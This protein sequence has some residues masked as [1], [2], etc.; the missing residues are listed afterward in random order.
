MLKITYKH[1]N[2]KYLLRHITTKITL[3]LLVSAIAISSSNATSEGKPC[4]VELRYCQGSFDFPSDNDRNLNACRDAL[5]NISA[6]CVCSSFNPCRG[7]LIKDVNSS[8]SFIVKNPLFSDLFLCDSIERKC[9]LQ[10]I[11][12][13]KLIP[14][15]YESQIPSNPVKDPAA[16]SSESSL[17]KEY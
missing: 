15:S 4:F 7:N 11:V 3:T 14:D 10:Q 9:D 5:K 1:E 2:M 17:P 8:E 13:K 16:F 6:D 12:A